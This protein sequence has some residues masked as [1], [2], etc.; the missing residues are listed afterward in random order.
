VEEAASKSDCVAVLDLLCDGLAGESRDQ[1]FDVDAMEDDVAETL[2][3]S[4]CAVDVSPADRFCS[5]CG[6]KLEES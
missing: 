4:K 6:E 3:C 1:D 2:K 5:N